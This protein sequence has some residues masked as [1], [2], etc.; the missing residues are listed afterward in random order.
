MPQQHDAIIVGGGHNGLV[1]TY[2]ARGGLRVLV[3]ERRDLLGG[4]C[5]TEEPFPGYRLSSCS[6]I[7]HLLLTDGDIRHLDIVPAQMFG[8]RPLP[9]WAADRT[10]LPGL[11]GTHP[12]GEVTGAPGH[13][14][15]QAILQ[16]LAGA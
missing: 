11:A 16:D 1:A 13:N 6:Y 4:A 2:L 3:L 12:G 8:R 14:A 9:G 10:P 7:C 15:A 5:I